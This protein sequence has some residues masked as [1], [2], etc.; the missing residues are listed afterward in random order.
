MAKRRVL[1]EAPHAW[2]LHFL[3]PGDPATRTGGYVY[4]ARILAELRRAGW[5]VHLHTLDDSFPDPTP[6][7]LAAAECL[8]ASLPERALTVIDGLALGGIPEAVAQQRDRLRLVALIHHPLAVETGLDGLTRARLYRDER[9]ALS[10]CRRVIVTSPNTAHALI[11]DYGVD[12][13]RLGVV[14]PGTDPAPLASGAPDGVPRLLCIATLTP[15]KGHAV[16]IEALAGLRD[17]PWRL[18]CIGSLTR[19]PETTA[20]LRALIER[21]ELQARVRLLG[22]AA[23]EALSSYYQAADLFVLP[24]Y[25]E[26][27]G[28]VL[29]EAVAHGLPIV[30]T[31]A[32]AIPDTVPPGAGL[33]VPP[34]D[35][36]AL[37]QALAR[38]LDD[39]ALR[40]EL[41][42][43]AQRARATLP[44]WQQA[45][46]AFAA[47]LERIGAGD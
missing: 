31:T 33:L 38:V 22:E 13:K 34:G 14:L 18:D 23:P 24:S 8:L 15:R 21:H 3:L 41:A 28:M 2:E 32:G 46:A 26:G 19:S 5:R 9:A 44:G 17:R 25:L 35:V 11:A 7:A 12:E 40:Q 47:E 42:I 39:V 20:Q 6:A 37:R 29:S 45:G 36:I 4:D 16:L 10:H 1:P 43:A 27:Y 30:S